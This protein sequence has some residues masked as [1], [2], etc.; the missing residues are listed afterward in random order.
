MMNRIRTK[1]GRVL[2]D[3]G[4]PEHLKGYTCL[5]TAIEL[6]VLDPMLLQRMM[7]GLYPAV[8]RRCQSTPLGV[9]RAMR[10]AIE[11]AWKRCDQRMQSFYFG[12]TLSPRRGKPANSEFIACVSNTLQQEE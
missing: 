7:D 11:A 6:T 8:A 5:L 1:A 2:R 9:E 12:N 4:V 3:L 10:H